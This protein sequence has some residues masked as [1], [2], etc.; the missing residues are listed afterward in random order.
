MEGEGQQAAFEQAMHYLHNRI[1]LLLSL[2]DNAI[3]A[4]SRGRIGAQ[5]GATPKAAAGS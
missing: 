5:P 1:T 3:D 2:P 4:L